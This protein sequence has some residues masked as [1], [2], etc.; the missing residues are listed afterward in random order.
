MRLPELTPDRVEAF[1]HTFLM[2]GLASPAPSPEFHY[3]MWTMAC[4]DH[5]KVVCAAPRSHAKSTALTFAYS[6]ASLLFRRDP[7]ILVVSNTY[8]L[9]TEFIRSIHYVLER[10]EKIRR[11][12]HIDAFEIDTQDDILVR[13]KDGYRFRIAALGFEG[14]VR[15]KNWGSQRPTLIIGDDMEDDEMVA[16]DDRRAKAANWFRSALL[17]VL[18]PKVGRMRIVGTF[19]HM[20]ALLVNLC[21]N[22]EWWSR[23]WEAHNDD[24]SEVLWPEQF[25]EEKLRKIRQEY[26]NGN[27]LDKYNCEYRNRV[28][29]DTSGYFRKAE[30]QPMSDQQ[31]SPE[32][33][34]KL[35]CYAGGDFAWS[36]KQNRD[37]TVLPIVYMD[38]DF[39]LYVYDLFRKQADGKEV[40]DEMCAM[41]KTYQPLVW[42]NERGA[43]SNSLNAA[44]EMRMRQTGAVLNIQEMPTHKEKTVRARPLQGFMRQRKVFFDTEAEWFPALQ[45]ELL[46]FPK[47]KHDDIVDAL[48]HIA[49]GV[50]EMPAPDTPEEEEEEEFFNRRKQTVV[51]GG[52]DVTTGY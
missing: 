33:R 47:G 11:F 40:V 38:H 34:K 23:V 10:N 39:N 15:G 48:A 1:L 12:F 18:D 49:I 50:S 3:D 14:S 45:Q 29:D 35:M 51:Q 24:F 26:I 7:Y 21:D 9:A 22:T 44:L 42:F 43:I 41:Q 2:D 31:K 16:S 13:L 30:F 6:L 52:R 5:P 19:L 28:I 4:S 25:D 46:E 36:Q 17:P 32:F 37:F 8:P 27:A 20:D